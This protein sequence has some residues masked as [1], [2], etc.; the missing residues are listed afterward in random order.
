[1][2]NYPNPLDNFRS[3]NYHFI[4]T[5]ANT[6]EALRKMIDMAGDNGSSYLQAINQASL[7]GEVNAGGQS[8]YLLLDTRRFS[9]F[10]VENY[11]MEHRYGTGPL[12]NPTVPTSSARMRVVDSTG[13]NFINFL[14]DIMRNKLQ[15]T[16]ASAFF[17]LAIVFTGHNDAIEQQTE[18]VATCF[19]P[20]MLMNMHFEFSNSGSVYDIELRE[21]EGN[22]A[23]GG[24]RQLIDLGEIQ[25]ISTQGTSNTLGGMIQA[26]EDRLNIRSLQYYQKYTN[27]AFAKMSSE[28]RESTDRAG[29]LVQ[30]MLTIPEEW[31]E[32]KLNTAGK[33]QNVEQVF[34][35]RSSETKSK[36]EAKS[37]DTTSS[38]IPKDR[39]SYHTFSYST[40]VPEAIN[41]ILASSKEFL[42]LASEDR[43]KQGT[44]IVHRTVVSVTSD[45]N[46][47]MIHFDIYPYSVPK[48]DEND[49]TVKTGDT[50]KN[51]KTETGQI[52]NLLHYNYLF[53]GR[54]SDVLD[55]K[56]DFAPTAAVALDM[57]L[58][59][60]G[61]R[62]A[63]NASTGQQPKDVK[64]TGQAKTDD[65]NL[66][67]RQAEPIF[68]PPKSQDQQTNFAGQNIEEYKKEEANRLTKAKQEHTN[69]LAVLHFM[70]SLN[71]QITVRGNPN[72][73]RK[74]ADRNV[75]GGIAKHPTTISSP[76]TLRSLRSAD[77]K[78][79]DVYQRDIKARLVSE[80]NMY[81][82]DYVE[83]R[84]KDELSKSTTNDPVL[85]GPDVAVGPLYMKVNIYSPNI[86]FL[87]NQNQ[88]DMF[89]NKFF[90]DGAYLVMNISTEFSGGSFKHTMNIIPFDPDGT[91]ENSSRVIA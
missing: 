40:T 11:A 52:K 63:E 75:R 47:Y 26:L 9:Q 42:E 33:S 62:L 2:N 30:Y 45:A 34:L 84:I 31:K 61:Q 12:S 5:V 54:N 55:L 27:E 41:I 35:A 64:E 90:Y 25:A 14:M 88:G 51:N 19:T 91:F 81:V 79:D 46:T 82:K 15:S 59:L 16:R 18:T 74:F 68:V 89:T 32:F 67:I 21:T 69:T 8:A 77:R 22:P 10:S 86:D 23:D 17:M 66:S 76:D 6:T 48:V 83:P 72:L 3:Y 37:N 39:A 57:D 85:H 20:M 60:G 78:A 29:K 53:S 56:V 36:D 49:K 65:F 44:A 4:L 1:M 50:A 87:G 38:S 24:L 73:I 80:K 28:Q 13:L 7:G 43:R 58:N 70:A 71:A